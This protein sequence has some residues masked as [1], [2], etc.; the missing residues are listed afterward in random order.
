[1]TTITI[2][3]DDWTAIGVTPA[4]GYV[5]VEP[6]EPIMGDNGRVVATAGAR[7]VLDQNGAAT[8]VRDPTVTGEGV[9]LVFN[10]HGF[11]ALPYYVAIPDQDSVT[12]VDLLQN[13]QLDP[14][15][16]TPMIPVPP[17]AQD[18]LAAAQTAVAAVAGFEDTKGAADGVASLD[19]AAKLEEAQVPARLSEETLAG[20][21]IA[22]QVVS[23]DGTDGLPEPTG[24][25]ME[26]VR[27]AGGL[28]DIRFDGVSL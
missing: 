23:T 13:H 17:S 7:V 14:S 3:F 10:V 22:G 19:E 2:G 27:N 9:K 28:D 4:A 12:L 16:L 20:S 1:M 11:P 6:A 24:V 18:V 5:T 26:F 8:L 21:F 15:T 25:G